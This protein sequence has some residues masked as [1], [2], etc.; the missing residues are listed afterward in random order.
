MKKKKV[1][2]LEERAESYN[3]TFGVKYPDSVLHVPTGR[4]ISGT[5]VL[6]NNYKGSGYYGSYPP[7]YLDRI[8][9][10]FPEL[11][12]KKTKV[13]HVFSGSLEPGNY[14]RFDKRKKIK[15]ATGEV[16]RPDVVGDA[17][18]LSDYFDERFDIVFADPPYSEECAEHYGT[19]MVKR[20]TVIIECAKV[21]KVGGYL[22]WMDQAPPQYRKQFF[23]WIGAIALWRSTMHRL[24]G[25]MIFR[26]VAEPVVKGSKD[27]DK[28]GKA[29]KKKK[30]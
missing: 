13:L 14:V 5:W 4:W 11:E 12:R 20:N 7:Q 18:V 6:G 26:K 19:P 21:L 3:T 10:V 25:V 8:S 30:K 28:A 24:R 1:Y 2:S 23:E 17:H 29:K 15:L 16:V 22:V 27:G 9:A